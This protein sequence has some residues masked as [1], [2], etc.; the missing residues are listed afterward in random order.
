MFTCLRSA[1]P[2]AS[3]I[4][5]VNAGFL[6]CDLYIFPLRPLREIGFVLAEI[7]G[8]TTSLLRFDLGRIISY[9]RPFIT[10]K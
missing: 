4:P 10:T 6:L 9:L 5:S 1:S 8:R 7:V 3:T 2:D